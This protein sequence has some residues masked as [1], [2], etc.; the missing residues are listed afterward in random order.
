MLAPARGA[1][2]CCDVTAPAIVPGCCARA[3]ENWDRT[4]AQK[5]AQRFIQTPDGR[6]DRVAAALRMCQACRRV[7]AA[8]KQLAHAELPRRDCNR[9]GGKVG[10]AQ[11]AR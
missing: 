8:P 4:R 1:P 5:T 7:V 3:I 2:V 10:A 6:E 11:H 9:P